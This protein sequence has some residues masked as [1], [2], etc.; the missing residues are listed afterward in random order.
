MI[1]LCFAVA[2]SFGNCDGFEE[3]QA[4][5]KD[6][7]LCLKLVQYGH[8]ALVNR[9]VQ[10]SDRRVAHWGA[11]KATAIYFLVGLLWELGVPSTR[12]KRIYGEI[13]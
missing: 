13:R 7:G 9:V 12:L 3:E 10:S 1:K 2:K 4:V 6:A 8:I 5:M 11:W